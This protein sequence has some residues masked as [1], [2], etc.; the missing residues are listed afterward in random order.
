MMYTQDYDETMFL[1]SYPI[2]GGTQLW[3]NFSQGGVNYPD[4]GLLQPYM[5]SFQIQDCPSAASIPGAG[6]VA[7]TAYGVNSAYLNPTDFSISPSQPRPVRLAEFSA[8]AE[9]V[10]MGDTA[11]LGNADGVLR[12]ITDIRPPFGT[13]VT[14][15]VV[16]ETSAPTIASV[17]ARH[18]ETAVVL[19][20]DGHVKAQRLV[21]RATNQSAA[22]TADAMR[23]SNVGDLIKGARTGV[24]AEDNFYF[25][26]SK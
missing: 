12:R 19:W 1:F 10:L 7:G 5:K 20:C 14:G 22:V 2:P 6:F 13:T 25:R 4:R 26:V 17:H 3:Y 8:P 16:T 11:F 15:G 21:Y 9:T 23:A 24:P 18:L